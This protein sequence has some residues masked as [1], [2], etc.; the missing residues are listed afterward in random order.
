MKHFYSSWRGIAGWF[1][2]RACFLPS[3][4]T[5]KSCRGK[6]TLV[7]EKYTIENPLDLFK[8]NAFGI[9][10]WARASLLLSLDGFLFHSILVALYCSHDITKHTTHLKSLSPSLIVQNWRIVVKK[11]KKNGLNCTK[12]NVSI[13]HANEFQWF[14]AVRLPEKQKKRSF[15]RH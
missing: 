3:K 11:K 6:V 13:L 4:L 9:I 15:W 7:N 8:K 1:S 2:S 10:M 14:P 12:H 5:F